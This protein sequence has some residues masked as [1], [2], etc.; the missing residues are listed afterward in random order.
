MKKI[1]SLITILS[2]CLAN[3]GTISGVTYFDYTNSEDESS[4]NFKRQYFNYSIT[5]SDYL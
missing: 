5:K 3:D 4:F 1:I 2:L